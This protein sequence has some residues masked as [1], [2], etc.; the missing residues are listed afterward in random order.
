MMLRIGTRSSRLAMAQATIVKNLI[1]EKL[2]RKTK[3]M[4][5]KTIGDYDQKS[6]L[7]KFNQQGIFTGALE[8]QLLQGKI[9]IAVHSL[10]DLPVQNTSGL[11]LLAFVKRHSAGDSLLIKK[12][13]VISIDPLHIT[14][15]LRFATGSPRRQSQFM[16]FEPTAIPIDIRGNI[17]TRINM[18]QKKSFDALIVASAV[19]E[20]IQILLP[21][22][23]ERIDL[24]VDYFPPTP[25][26]GTIAIQGRNGEFNDIIT[27]NDKETQISVDAERRALANTGGGCELSLGVY[28]RKELNKWIVCASKAAIG[29]NPSYRAPLSRFYSTSQDLGTAMSQLIKYL[30]I[31]NDNVIQSSS[32]LMGRK[33]VLTGSFARMNDYREVL[34]AEGAITYVLPVFSYRTF[35]DQLENT[36][37]L[38]RWKNCEWLVISSQRAVEFVR[39]LQ[40]MIPLTKRVAC[41][42]P[43]TAKALRSIDSP[44]HLV[45]EGSMESLRELL[46]EL[47][48]SYSGDVLY[49]R[50]VNYAS[51]PADDAY[52][53][54]VY[55]ALVNKIELSI[56]PTEIVV[57]SVRAAKAILEYLEPNQ[58]LRWI[59]IGSRTGRFLQEMGLDVIVSNQ[60][61]PQA[62]LQAV[63]KHNKEGSFNSNDPLQSKR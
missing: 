12:S 53:F 20:R 59:A 17:E 50:G 46:L 19:F 34:T 4:I 1:E 63:L 11:E 21:D 23:I 18:L 32:I 28:V 7:T 26:Q 51:T 9:D 27:L 60:P 54:P 36:E 57:F 47:R 3:L 13:H 40:Q 39:L 37:L 35:F 44:V 8:S 6:R 25:G 16:E 43:A 10:K 49:L 38:K 55:E 33:I 30:T 14:K 29:W 5:V 42:G 58:I 24:P 22:N 56:K 62:V 61:T 41:I 31:N 2:E 45:A 48:E 15:Y 52:S